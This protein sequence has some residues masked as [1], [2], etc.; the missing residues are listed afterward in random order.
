MAATTKNLI[1]LA[2]L[3][4]HAAMFSKFAMACA[5]A[6]RHGVLRYCLSAILF[7]PVVPLVA[8]ASEGSRAWWPQFRG[9]QGAGVGAE[10]SDFPIH[11]GPG[12]NEVWKTSLPTGHSSPC[13]WENLIFLTGYE[14]DR[15]LTIALDRA[16]GRILWQQ[17]VPPERVELGAR[18]SNPASSTP[19][20]DG[21]FVYVYFGSFGLICYDFDGGEEWRRPL[22]VPVT[23]HG[24]SASPVLAG[25]LLIVARDA[26]VNA[27]L[28]AVDKRNGETVWKAGRAGFR[29]GF[30]TP[31]LWPPDDP[32]QAV[33][34]GTLR[35]V[36]YDL[37][38]GAETWSVRGLPNEMVSSPTAG[39]GLI[40]VAGWTYGS[41]VR[42]MPAFES[43][44][45][46]DADG[47]E[48]LTR[49]EAPSGPAKQ[50]FV[51]IDADKD[52][53]LT[54]EEWETMAEIFNSSENALL[55]VRPGGEGDVT[56]TRVAWKQT[57][58]L[59]YVPSPLYYEGRLYVVKNGGLASCFDARSGEVFYQEE[60]LGALGDYYA[61][62]VAAGG[63]VVMASQQGVAVVMRAAPPLEILARN[64]F[65]EAILATP[66]L[67][68]DTIYVR[69]VE[70]LGA[71]RK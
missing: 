21:R 67:V 25:N 43:L 58:G 66:A 70:A 50:H 61:S 54:R 62:P 68:G 48:R 30:A 2:T 22:P 55:A 8:A 46:A 15:L 19:V 28:L 35:L 45:H 9:P 11:F 49:G 42:H 34:P 31:L 57:R 37:T 7:A 40:Y 20:T 60:R 56:G 39:G 41:G 23:Q 12:T 14:E 53:F 3:A 32:C 36:A 71:F 6:V 5:R 17:S 4:E 47:D 51:Y 69:T 24:A 26:D 13:I 18:L 29:R 65:D 27:H 63:K 33:L 1:K 16:D 10:D 38:D 52:G 44:L 64:D 59:P